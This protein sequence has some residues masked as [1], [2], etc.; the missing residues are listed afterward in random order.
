MCYILLGSRRKKLDLFLFLEDK[1][2]ENE[3]DNISVRED[4]IT[5][6][7]QF[8]DVIGNVVSDNNYEYFFRGENAF[9]STACLP[10][11]FRYS[12]GGINNNIEYDSYY[13]TLTLFPEEFKDLS[14][15]DIL[16]KMQHY[17]GVTR[18]LDVTSNPLVALYF[19]LSNK[20]KKSNNSTNNKNNAD[21]FDDNSYVYIFKFKKEQSLS[22]DSDKALFLSTLPKL[23]NDQ[24]KCIFEYSSRHQKVIIKPGHLNDKVNNLYC[25]IFDNC[26][27]NPNEKKA[28]RKLIY[29]CE[30][31]RTALLKNHRLE[32]KDL[33]ETYHVYSRY[34]NPRIKAQSGSFILFGL[35]KNKFNNDVTGKITS[36]SDDDI[37]NCIG[38]NMPLGYPITVIKIN[39][40]DVSKIKKDL[41]IICNINDATMLKDTVSEFRYVKNFSIN[42]NKGEQS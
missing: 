26:K 37:K 31:E 6:L 8:I 28:F 38:Q 14:N 11:L 27:L 2:V 21:D 25:Y 40:K 29:E 20:T 39:K 7:S 4:E 32:V 16:C 30:R 34:T 18:L 3:N 15:L 24:K 22:F 23:K 10:N 13:K 33:L 1:P 12:T 41:D 36:P 17:G 35:Q 19:A 42:K 5:N 9:Y